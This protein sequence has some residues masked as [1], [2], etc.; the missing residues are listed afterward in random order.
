MSFTI[1]FFATASG[2]KPVH[3][4]I[5]AQDHQTQDKLYEVLTYLREYGFHL[6]TT[7]LRR[8]S[9]S[10]R[11]WELRAKYQ[12]RQYRIFLAKGQGQ[13]VILLHALV[14]K[15]PKTL[16]QDIQTAEQRLQT[17]EKGDL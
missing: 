17:Y 11:L 7:Y 6:S 3:E 12:S 5:L 9:G 15:T 1:E 2:R 8:M 14:K 16:K 4:F 10:K 13:S